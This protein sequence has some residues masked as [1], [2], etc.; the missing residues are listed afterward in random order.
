MKNTSQ[1]ITSM[2]SAD[3]KV[4]ISCNACKRRE[5]DSIRIRRYLLLN[6]YSVVDD[7]NQ[8]D[9]IFFFS[10]AFSKEMSIDSHKRLIDFCDSYNVVFVFGCFPVIGMNSINDRE[11]LVA[12]HNSN[13]SE[14][15]NF[16]PPR[17][18]KF[19]DIKDGND[20]YYDPIFQND[21]FL[22]RI[23][24]GCFGNC[25][26]CAIKKAIGTLCS[27]ELSTIVFELESAIKLGYSYIRLVA[28]DGGGYGLD[29]QTD[30]ISLLDTIGCYTSIK[31][32]EFEINP[33]WLLKYGERFVNYIR[34]NC[35]LRYKLT[36]PI[37]S[38][39]KR[40]LID[41]HRDIDLDAFS[42]LLSEIWRTSQARLFLITHIITGYPGENRSDLD[43]T[44]DFLIRNKF[45]QINVFPFTLNPHSPIGLSGCLFVDNVQDHTNYL[46]LKL[47][48]CGYSVFE[49]SK[50]DN[51]EWQHVILR[52]D[53]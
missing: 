37:Q 47:C 45:H 28:D 53:D 3:V 8:A 15:E 31:G 49:S 21:V 17:R 32:L 51:K 6:D 7:C 38:A 5:L 14:V 40:L 1:I 41:M 48:E 39:S 29:R 42:T 4:F 27:K 18:L 19:A 46:I 24:S 20:M 22:I 26:Y 50:T 2:V 16:F 11:N 44:L 34:H 10:C 30:L 23:S 35:D 12:I 13:L 25:S 36:I 33:K 52:L 9:V 43:A